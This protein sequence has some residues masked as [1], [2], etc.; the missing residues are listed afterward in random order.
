MTTIKTR[1]SRLAAVLLVFLL[2][3]TMVGFTGQSFE[4]FASLAPLAGS[5]Y[6]QHG[7]GTSNDPFQIWTAE[8]LDNVRNSLGASFVMMDDICLAAFPSW[9]PI[10]SP[11]APFTGRFSGRP[12][13][14]MVRHAILNI[15]ISR[16]D[17]DY[18]GLFGFTRDAVIW[19]MGIASGIIVGGVITGGIVG[20]AENTM[21]C[22]T[23]NRAMVG[24]VEDLRLPEFMVRFDA[25]GGVIVTDYGTAYAEET[26]FF[27]EVVRFNENALPPAF[28][29]EYRNFGTQRFP[30]YA[31]GY[32]SVQD[33]SAHRI[34][35]RGHTLVAWRVVEGHAGAA[36]LRNYE[37][38]VEDMVLQ[39]VWTPNFYNVRFAPSYT[40]DPLAFRDA[41]GGEWEQSV[42]FG[43]GVAQG[44]RPVPGRR[45]HTFTGEWANVTTSTTQNPY[46]IESTVE[47]IVGDTDFRAE[48]ETNIYTVTFRPNFPFREGGNVYSMVG[49]MQTGGGD[50]V[51][52]IAFRYS[53][54]DVN[55]PILTAIGATFQGWDASGDYTTASVVEGN[56]TFTA[57]WQVNTYDVT[58]NIGA[59]GGGTFVQNGGTSVAVRAD[60]ND[61]ITPPTINFA[62]GF[63]F[64][65]WQMV[66]S[67]AS[68]FDPATG[69]ITV[70][71]TDTFVA[72]FDRIYFTVTFDPNGGNF[73]GNAG[74]R[75]ERVAHGNNATAPNPAPVRPGFTFAGWQG[76]PN[77]ITANTT[78]RAQWT[79]IS[80]NITYSN[81][82]GVAV[83]ANHPRTFTVENTIV[84]PPL[85]AAPTGMRF[86]RWSV[87]QIGPGRIGN[88]T[89]EPIFEYVNHAVTFNA[90]GNIASIPTA[91]AGSVGLAGNANQSVR[92]NLRA[93][94][95]TVSAQGARFLGW[96]VNGAG[97][98][99]T[100]AEVNAR[101]IT[102]NTNFV[103][104]WGAIQHRVTFDARGHT[105]VGSSMN[106]PHQNMRFWNASNATIH[107]RNT[108]VVYVNHGANA[109]FP[110]GNAPGGRCTAT[111]AN[112]NLE[113]WSRDLTRAM[114]HG[115]LGGIVGAT[116]I[117]A[118]WWRDPGGI[119]GFLSGPNA[120]VRRSFN[121][122]EINGII[123]GGI[124]GSVMNGARVE[125][126]YNT[127]TVSGL[128][129]DNFVGGIVGH[130]EEGT[131]TRAWSTGAIRMICMDAMRP[132]N[133]GTSRYT[134]GGL[135]GFVNPDNATYFSHMVYDA[136]EDLVTGLYAIG[137]DPSSVARFGRTRD[138]M[139][140]IADSNR[141]FAGFFINEVIPEVGEQVWYRSQDG[142]LPRLAW[143]NSNPTF[144]MALFDANGGRLAH[145]HD[146][147]MFVIDGHNI[148]RAQA[149]V[150]VR[151]GYS[152]LGFS[153][154]RIAPGQVPNDPELRDRLEN[155]FYLRNIA[156]VRDHSNEILPV[157][158]Y[159]VWE[160][161]Q[162]DVRFELN[163]G[164]I[165]S[166]D[167]RQSVEYGT[168]AVAPTVVRE[169]YFLHGW[170]TNR[171]DFGG[172]DTHTPG[173]FNVLRGEQL[174]NTPDS[175]IIF[176]ARWRPNIQVV[177]RIGGAQLAPGSAPTTQFVSW[178]GDAVAPTPVLHNYRLVGW[179]RV[180]QDIRV[181]DSSRDRDI[182][183]IDAEWQYIGSGLLDNDN[184]TSGNIG[185]GGPGHQVGVDTPGGAPVVL[186][187]NIWIW[188][189]LILVALILLAVA[190]VLILRI[191]KGKKAAAAVSGGGATT[192]RTTVRV[193]Q[194]PPAQNS[195][196]IAS[197][198]PNGGYLGGGNTQQ[199]PPYG[200]GYANRPQQ[201]GYQRPPQQGGNDNLDNW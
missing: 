145:F 150:Y 91:N 101:I 180:Y 112:F 90:A 155:N 60:H 117:Y 129:S 124:V 4:G 100:N 194:V 162:L 132:V 65:G 148:P 74:S 183:H 140:S 69:R 20:F 170:E 11:E 149:P 2:G 8:D 97:A 52:Q 14:S 34:F 57:R 154:V 137:G 185:P 54:A 144:V 143:D 3:F 165:V 147:S 164:T 63:T 108:V 25:G 86:V 173:F 163:G 58:F 127:G 130:L 196:Y 193:N 13:G 95:P 169:G 68:V 56:M 118:S 17:E 176:F 41:G 88:I 31:V 92:H 40:G 12:Y 21:I 70:R 189:V 174:P 106:Q 135:I 113:G 89:I 62:P 120:I 195:G 110:G 10:G 190:I 159:A 59:G 167:A 175:D 66:S 77:N 64:R 198:R 179:N 29:G 72:N 19:D 177:F 76:N 156:A 107:N 134:M 168:R 75:T 181:Y 71:S 182:I 5:Q 50:L 16:P 61:V 153:R 9:E 81:M 38:I 27:E 46:G 7:S 35:R 171:Y 199:R 15:N 200:G 30:S 47:H 131:V 22:S 33:M 136:N 116:T 18:M 160:V 151:E 99:L 197:S 186:G 157:R 79:A 126:V 32:P 141:I 96:R 123:A 36:S 192:T 201:G 187:L 109:S 55:L 166:G 178:G 26:S 48:W 104:N 158:L 82:R 37:G 191:S 152:F 146:Q 67:G 103:A 78:L 39:A 43:E 49:G 44:N 188:L 138:E 73:A 23:F 102:G 105:R 85:A 172:F 119:A 142:T 184:D 111:N 1:L 87:P 122:G 139:R 93:T 121:T 24:S 51:Q 28:F 125:D 84:V 6:F 53:R 98:N 161:R 80:F 94:A 42:R 114:N 115:G 83:P 133:R 45:G 128:H